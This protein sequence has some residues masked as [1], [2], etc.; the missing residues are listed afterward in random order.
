MDERLPTLERY[1]VRLKL[2]LT[3]LVGVLCLF[4]ALAL[5]ACQPVQDIPTATPWSPTP[6]AIQPAPTAI[7]PTATATVLDAPTPRVMVQPTAT[8]TT[9]PTRT[10][11]APTPTPRVAPT[12]RAT[13]PP[14]PRVVPTSVAPTPAPTVA[15]P[16]PPTTVPPTPTIAPPTP[17]ATVPPT[18][19]V[20]PTATAPPA[21][22]I[23]GRPALYEPVTPPEHL[24]CISG[25][26]GAT[27]WRL[28]TNWRSP[29][30]STTMSRL[31]RASGV[32]GFT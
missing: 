9:A 27:L 19:T 15:P 22:R 16:T 17:T 32:T 23:P 12:P 6:T 26:N 30:P 31:H 21:T 14:T 20:A 2:C 8:A 18:P 28:S 11:V 7:P 24:A 4:L 5:A 29:S 1:L 3:L 25:G 13:V 10:S